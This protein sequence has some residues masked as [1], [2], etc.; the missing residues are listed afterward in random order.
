MY[1]A[2]ASVIAFLR[3]LV[4]SYGVQFVKVSKTVGCSLV[5]V[6]EPRLQSCSLHT[7]QHFSYS[8]ACFC[9]R[10]CMKLVA[11]LPVVA[12]AFKLF[13][14]TA[15]CCLFCVRL[16]KPKPAPQSQRHVAFLRNKLTFYRH[17]VLSHC[18]SVTLETSLKYLD[19]L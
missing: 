5:V 16:H 14:F 17:A 15:G 18:C 4:L 6:L 3:A 13:S 9:L 12:I 1:T 8:A 7:E 19:Y 11:L 2:T 10:C